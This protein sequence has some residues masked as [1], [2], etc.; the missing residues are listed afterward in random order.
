MSGHIRELCERFLSLFHRR[1]LD[2]DLGEE[3]A[4]HVEMAV[5]DNMRA[6]MSPDEARRQAMIRLG[7]V[8]AT[9]ELHRDARGMP[10][11][12][13]FARDLR[14]AFRTLRHDAGLCEAHT[15]IS[16]DVNRSQTAEPWLRQ[17][18]RRSEFGRVIPQR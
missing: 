14:Y 15:R 3:L 11:I 7:G 16:L 8:E 5:E 6:G 12:E 2:S 4:T 18:R 9:K 10:L 17:V 1:K 13:G